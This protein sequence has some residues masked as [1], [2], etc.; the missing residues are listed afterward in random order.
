MDPEDLEPKKQRQAGLGQEDLSE[1]SISELK[2][3][4]EALQAEITRCE[5]LIR[6]KEGSRSAAESVFKK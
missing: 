4:I 6:S 2:E 3:R 1:W 5:A